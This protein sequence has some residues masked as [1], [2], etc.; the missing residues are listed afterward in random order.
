MKTQISND[1][2]CGF[3]VGIF[4]KNITKKLGTVRV[5]IFMFFFHTQSLKMLSFK[6]WTKIRKI[7]DKTIS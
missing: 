1:K 5:K 6:H 3:D 2:I 4:S 7:K